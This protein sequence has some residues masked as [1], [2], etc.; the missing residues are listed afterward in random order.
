MIRLFYIS[1]LLVTFSLAVMAQDH[2]V[3]QRTST[4]IARKQT[5]MLVRELGIQDSIMQHTLFQLHLKYAKMREISNTRHEALLRMQ[6]MREELKNI[7]GP[8]LFAAFMNRQVESSS[9][10]PKH[11]FNWIVTASNSPDTLSSTTAA[12]QNPAEPSVSQP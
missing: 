4:D 1:I 6:A 7:L 12:E 11:P 5:E 2:Y 3:P 9:R 8:E 10:S